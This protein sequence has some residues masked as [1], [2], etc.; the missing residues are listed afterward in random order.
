MNFKLG[1]LFCGPGGLGYA[2]SQAKVE[3]NN[4]QYTIEP[5]WATDIDPD[6]CKTYDQN[7]HGGKGIEKGKVIVSPVETL[8]IETLSEINAFAFGFPCNDFSK[9]GER[10]GINGKYGPLYTAGVE[11]LNRHKPDWFLA[12]NVVG[13]HE[14]NNEKT[15]SKILDELAKADEGYKLTVHRYQFEQYSVPQNRHRIIIVGIAQRFGHHFRVPAPTTPDK[16]MT[17]KEAIEDTP[18]PLGTPSES[19]KGSPESDIQAHGGE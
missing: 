4:T 17:A 13:L 9:V 11:V 5:T 15:F 8:S 18:I 16:A 1:E 14:K 3:N 2:A 7:I 19:Q 12:E 10:N 6:A